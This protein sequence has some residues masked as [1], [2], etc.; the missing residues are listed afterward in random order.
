[1]AIKAWLNANV[2]HSM[3]VWLGKYEGIRE[4]WGE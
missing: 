3:R 4:C 2:G 1:M